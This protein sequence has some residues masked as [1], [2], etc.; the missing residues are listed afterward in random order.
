MKGRS[1]GEREVAALIKGTNTMP[2][3]LTW[4]VGSQMRR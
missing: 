2:E 1:R 4:M 3:E